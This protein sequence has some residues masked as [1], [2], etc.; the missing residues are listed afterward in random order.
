M[1]LD[2][3]EEKSKGPVLIRIKYAIH[4]TKCIILL[5]AIYYYTDLI[6]RSKT[7]AGVENIFYSYNSGKLYIIIY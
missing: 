5:H 1:C 4:L 3:R 6:H 2:A 7:P